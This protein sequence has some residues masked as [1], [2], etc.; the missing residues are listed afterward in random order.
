MS[1]LEVNLSSV[2]DVEHLSV[3]DIVHSRSVEKES[4]IHVSQ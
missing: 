2:S 1:Q 3:R 4:Y